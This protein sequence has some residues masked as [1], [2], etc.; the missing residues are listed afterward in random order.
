M[1]Y[2]RNN[3][4]ENLDN[5]CRLELNR[6]YACALMGRARADQLLHVPQLLMAQFDTLLIQCRH[7]EYMHEVVW[8]TKIL[9]T[10]LQ[11]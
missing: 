8:F 5:F 6:G 1:H 7:T 10:T 11:L 9:L 2:L 4:Y 3:S